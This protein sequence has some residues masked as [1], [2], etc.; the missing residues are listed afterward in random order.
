MET[1]KQIWGRRADG[2]WTVTNLVGLGLKGKK[3][4][5]D[6]FFAVQNDLAMKQGMGLPPGTIRSVM[7]ESIVPV[8]ANFRDETKLHC[9]GTGFFISC[10]GLLIT[11]AH[12]ITDPIE[13]KYGGISEIDERSWKTSD[14]NLGILVA[15]NPLFYG[16]RYVFYPIEWSGFLA[17][18]VPHPI[19]FVTQSSLKLQTDVAI[20]KVRP[21]PNGG[22]HQPLTIIQPS[23]KGT[24]LK[25]G[26]NVDALGYPNMPETVDLDG[27]GTVQAPFDMHVST[28]KLI[29]W[30]PDSFA[31][32]TMPAPGPC[33]TFNAKIPAGMSGGPIFDREGIYVHGVVSMGSDT[34]A[35][36]EAFS[37][38][39]MMAPSLNIPIAPLNG[40]TPLELHAGRSEGMALVQ[41]LGL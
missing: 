24:S 2:Q 31:N 4:G 39:S 14:M 13:R 16:R 1:L 37:Y 7:G 19:P 27:D 9:I 11:A 15:A 20:C 35:G 8:V 29:E 21:R 28:G 32:P 33:F 17:E 22:A 10:S 3:S 40:A 12:V 25:I 23:I 18:K 5:S 26:A 38:G 6:N 41:G 36:H 34:E 30:V